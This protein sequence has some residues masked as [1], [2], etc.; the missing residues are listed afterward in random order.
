M[1]LITARSAG[2]NAFVNFEASLEKKEVSLNCNPALWRALLAVAEPPS[3]FAAFSH[4][5]SA[6][7]AFGGIS[8]SKE[9]LP[10]TPACYSFLSLSSWWLEA[11]THPAG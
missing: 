4:L 5:L 3:N 1:T 6:E 9:E 11:A 2:E 10:V 7:A 8:T